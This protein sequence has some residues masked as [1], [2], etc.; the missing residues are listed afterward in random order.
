METV[1][2]GGV[3]R[4]ATRVV[5]NN[6]Q[7]DFLKRTAI[8]KKSSRHFCSKVC[9]ETY[10][11]VEVICYKCNTQVWKPV[12]KLKNS[13][14]GL[15]FCSRVCKDSCQRIGGVL[16]LDHYGKVEKGYRTLAF[17]HYDKEC[18]ECGYKEFEEGL[19]VH[20]IDENRDNNEL[21]NLIILCATHHRLVTFGIAQII[22]RQYCV[23][24]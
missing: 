6:C 16:E 15:Y 19:E 3:K 12:S 11:R 21:S 23:V 14:S 5:C 4:P 7:K 10:G 13:K 1:L 2:C 22:D 9:N 17:R 20:H 8:A 18:I 24:S